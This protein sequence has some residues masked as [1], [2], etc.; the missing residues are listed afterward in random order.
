MTIEEGSALDEKYVKSLG[1]FDVVY[2]WGVLHHTG[3]CGER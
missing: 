2:S 1:T 3:E